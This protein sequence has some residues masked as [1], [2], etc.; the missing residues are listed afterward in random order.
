MLC[1]IYLPTAKSIYI[2][3]S[4]T[5]FCLKGDIAQ[6]VR[7][8]ASHARGPGFE[9]LYLH[10]KRK[11]RNFACLSF[12]L[13][14]LYQTFYISPANAPFRIF[15]KHKRFFSAGCLF[16]IIYGSRIN[17]RRFFGCSYRDCRLFI[18]I[19]TTSGHFVKKRL[20]A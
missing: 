9:P 6:P 1:L 19:S 13:I 14:G 10:Q 18:P 2:S 4:L 5:P 12:I 16:F 20:F 11:T 3:M 15:H 17:P 7:A 8:F